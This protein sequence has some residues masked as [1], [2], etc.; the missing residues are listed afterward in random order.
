[1]KKN[2]NEE[3]EIEEEQREIKVTFVYGAMNM[4]EAYYKFIN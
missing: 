2:R 4:K 3:P 1:M